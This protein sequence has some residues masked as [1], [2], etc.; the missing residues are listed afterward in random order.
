MM[1]EIGWKIFIHSVGGILT[2]KERGNCQKIISERP[3]FTSVQL[4][5]S[6]PVC[7]VGQF[8]S[9]GAL[10]ECSLW[11]LTVGILTCCKVAL[12]SWPL[13]TYYFLKSG[14]Y[15]LN[16]LGGCTCDTKSTIQ[17]RQALPPVSILQLMLWTQQH[18]RGLGHSATPACPATQCA[19]GWSV[20]SLNFSS[21]SIP[22]NPKLLNI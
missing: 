12:G 17:P 2:G 13:H 3:S 5:N 14:V 15:T 4:T 10:H 7:T 22:Q 16:C 6:T 18:R 8:I 11:M 19:H 9:P 1:P 21:M 20:L